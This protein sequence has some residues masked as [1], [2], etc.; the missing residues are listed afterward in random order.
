M[1]SS[2]HLSSSAESHGALRTRSTL[3][4]WPICIALIAAFA[5]EAA[6]YLRMSESARPKASLKPMGTAS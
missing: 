2:F 5:T 1:F 4:K 3:L 6:E